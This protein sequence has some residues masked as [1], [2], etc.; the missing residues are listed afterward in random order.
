[1]HQHEQSGRLP[2]HLWVGVTGHRRLPPDP[3][4]ADRVREVLAAIQGALSDAKLPPVPLGVV[5][6]LAEGADRLIAREILA[7]EG[8]RLEVILPFPAEEYLRDFTTPA[9]REEFQ[10]LLGRASAVTVVE[11]AGS[12]DEAY[13]E[14]GRR[15]ADRCDALIALWDGAKSRGSAERPMS[16]AT[17]ATRRCRSTGSGPAT[18]AG[19][20][21]PSRTPSASRS[22]GSARSTPTT[23]PGSADP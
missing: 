11:P 14:A 23:A 16:S 12:R 10:E 21:S 15:T 20:P 13:A 22:P 5:S 2:Y 7:A 4:L 6:S 3:A 9:S 1:M 18:T 19:T 8:G 17:P